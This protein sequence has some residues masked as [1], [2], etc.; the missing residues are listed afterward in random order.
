MFTNCCLKHPHPCSSDSCSCLVDQELLVLLRSQETS[1][2]VF[3]HQ[4]VNPLLGQVK[5]CWGQINQIPQG[6]ILGEV[7]NVHLWLEEYRKDHEEE[8][9]EDK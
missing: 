6:H 7:V 8:D 2:G 3:L 1:E 9:S 5:G 4:S